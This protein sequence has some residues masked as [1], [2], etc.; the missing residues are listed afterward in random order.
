[1]EHLKIKLLALSHPCLRFPTHSYGHVHS[2]NPVD[3]V[4]LLCF[5]KLETLILRLR[6]TVGESSFR[7][8]VG[9]QVRTHHHPKTLLRSCDFTSS[10]GDHQKTRTDAIPDDVLYNLVTGDELGKLRAILKG[11]GE[12][13]M[14]CLNDFM[15]GRFKNSSKYGNHN[16]IQTR[17]DPSAFGSP[18]RSQCTIL[19]RRIFLLAN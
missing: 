5:A 2:L 17:V 11:D 8:V 12:T 7:S 13:Q 18:P 10:L 16:I 4:S 1:M 6:K 3:Q 15:A 19:S 9:R 14:Q